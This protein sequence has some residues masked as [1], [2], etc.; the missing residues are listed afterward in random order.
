MTTINLTQAEQYEIALT[1]E[2]DDTGDAEDARE[3]LLLES[4]SHEVSWSEVDCVLEFTDG[5]IYDIAHQETAKDMADFMTGVST[6]HEGAADSLDAAEPLPK[7]VHSSSGLGWILVEGVI[8]KDYFLSPIDLPLTL[9]GM[10]RA[11]AAYCMGS[12]DWNE[13][14]KDAAPIAYTEELARLVGHRV[15][16]RC[17]PNTYRDRR[18][19]TRGKT[20]HV[21][22][23]YLAYPKVMAVGGPGDELP[24][25]EEIAKFTELVEA[26][27]GTCQGAT[28]MANKYEVVEIEK[29]TW[30]EDWSP[31]I[32]N[33]WECDSADDARALC[34]AREF[35]AE[36]DGYHDAH[37]QARVNDEPMDADDGLVDDDAVRTYLLGFGYTL[38]KVEE[39]MS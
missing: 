25:K 11:G 19:T 33:R 1:M 7:F 15:L 20:Y 35:E 24:D 17:Q 21:D 34:E 39:A 5:S 12:T 23:Q 38:E 14:A 8:E 28:H 16:V 3:Q 36:L 29:G 22:A 10:R 27:Y 9:T 37:F 2:D 30:N 31:S 26:C 6:M 18:A 4:T 13:E 32:T